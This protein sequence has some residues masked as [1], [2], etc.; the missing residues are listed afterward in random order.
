[1]LGT[2]RTRPDG[3]TVMIGTTGHSPDRRLAHSLTIRP[4]ARV[5][6]VINDSLDPSLPTGHRQAPASTQ[7][8]GSLSRPCSSAQAA[9][10]TRPFS[11]SLLKIRWRWLATVRS[12]ITS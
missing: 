10:C 1:M 5:V 4:D 9:S 11:P 7:A 6:V 3:V 8:G 2:V 12:L